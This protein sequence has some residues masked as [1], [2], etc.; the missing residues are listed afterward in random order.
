M[1][2]WWVRS[3]LAGALLLVA[4][5]RGGGPAD[6]A[7]PLPVLR[8][9][10]SGDYPP[11]SERVDAG[12]ERVGARPG[13]VDYVGFDV[14]AARSLA[15]DL[16][17]TVE[18]VPF[19]WPELEAAL[20]SG[21]FD[22][23]MS[24]V[25]VRP[26]RSVRGRFTLPVAETG[27]VVLVR[28]AVLARLA[29]GARTDDP[30]RGLD[31][32]S[33]R[34][35]VNAGGHLER[36]TRARFRRAAIVAIP[37]N[38]AVREALADAD[39]EAAVTDTLE[40]PGWIRDLA[41]VSVVGPVT[42]DRKAWWL[43]PD[44]EVLARRLD[45]WLLAA[46]ADGTLAAWRGEW[47]DAPGPRTAE[48]LAALLAACDE[49]LALMPFVAEYKRREGLPV[50][51]PSRE[52]RVLAAAIG[53]VREAARR[54]GRAAPDEAAVRDFYRAQ[55][56]AAVEVQQRVLAAE[57]GGPGLEPFDLETELR[58]ALL[59]IGDRMA[60]LLPRLA[61]GGPVGPGQLDRRV[62]AALEGHGLSAARLDAIGHAIAAVR[63]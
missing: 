5:C 42:R 41:G 1:P 9:G 51:D 50:V 33:L 46:E 17:Y 20:A 37:D 63:D 53:S 45:A 27:A 13:P 29:V 23:A 22:V 32:A 54:E 58:P 36:V 35:A 25:T 3:L 61:N 40:A 8:V 19:R 60:W 47:F 34:V 44:A 26:E 62:R 56:D 48:P 7:A 55:I 57:P 4:A 39:V 24:G 49:R 18:W 28:T 43:S 16:G 31:D 11:F 2:S 14:S 52:E 12:T 38:R 59:R 21:R 15:H 6:P 10:V 30:L